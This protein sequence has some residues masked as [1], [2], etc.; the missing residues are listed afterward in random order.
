MATIE[1]TFNRTHGQAQSRR[2]NQIIN[3]EFDAGGHVAG[4]AVAL[5][6]I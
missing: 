6:L 5:G 4:E 1:G 3:S 2:E